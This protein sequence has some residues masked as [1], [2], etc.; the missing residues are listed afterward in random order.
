MISP[1]PWHS[2]ASQK[3]NRHFFIHDRT[4]RAIAKMV[5]ERPTS[6]MLSD[7]KIMTAAPELLRALKSAVAS[8]YA[9]NREANDEDY[10]LWVQIAE[11]AIAKAEGKQT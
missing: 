10:P 7:L 5:A 8:E 6:E 2:S 9:M 11:A 1:T 3:V 4:G